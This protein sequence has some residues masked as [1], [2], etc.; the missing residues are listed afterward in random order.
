[1]P[2]TL[3]PP[4][5]VLVI[6]DNMDGADSLARFLRVGA[7]YDVRV[8][9][10]G[11]TGAR[12]AAAHPPDAVVCD[13]A[14][15]RLNGYQ[16]AQRIAAALPAK[17]LLIAVTAFA[18]EH[19]EERTKAAGFDC[20]LVKPA[21]PFIIESLIRDLVKPP[22]PAPDHP[23]DPALLAAIRARPSD[24]AGW[25]DL[26]EWLRDNGRDDE[27]AVVRVLW[28]GIRDSLAAGRTL[29]SALEY[30]RRNAARLGQQARAFEARDA[31]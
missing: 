5:S 7:G 3:T 29:D 11:A 26:A 22:G 20:Y 16:V 28:P 1:M 18:A 25:Q 21:D 13:I 6:E 19:T 9:Y 14:L 12:L 10:D 31:N 17:P 4:V 2:S 23:F 24:P 8:A 30:V 15:P 27:A